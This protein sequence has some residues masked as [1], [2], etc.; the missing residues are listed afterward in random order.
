MLENRKDHCYPKDRSTANIST[1]FSAIT[2]E[3]STS[4]K[5]SSSVQV[6]LKPLPTASKSAWGYRDFKIPRVRFAD[7][8]MFARMIS[9][10][11]FGELSKN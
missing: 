5:A 8:C 11:R 2:T 10:E 6:I 4:F 7:G 1:T 9:Q 3:S